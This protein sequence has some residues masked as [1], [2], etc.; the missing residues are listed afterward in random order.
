M[1]IKI[2]YNGKYPNLCRGALKVTMSDGKEWI[3]PKYC[4]S[5]CGSAYFTSDY[6]ESIITNGPWSISDWP[7]DFPEDCKG[8]VTEAV[9]DQV[10]LGCC[11]GC[12]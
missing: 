4:L 1:T 10:S 3:F 2:D 7:K 11:G 6:S 5:S 12:L 9:N 8:S